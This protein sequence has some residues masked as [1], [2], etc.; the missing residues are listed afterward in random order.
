MRIRNGL[1][2]LVDEWLQ[3][4]PKGKPPHYRYRAAA[5]ELT[6]RTMPIAGTRAFLDAAYAQ[7]HQNWLDAIDA[8]YTNPS[9]ENWRW[10][11]NL[12]MSPKNKSPETKLEKAV[13]DACGDNWSNQ[14]PV[15]SGL[16]GPN[17]D[18]RV[19]IDLAHRK[20]PS[21]FSLIELKVASDN[22]LFAAIEIL[23]Y[24]LVFVWSKSN[25]EKLGYDL[26]TQPVLA[27]ND[28]TLAVL[29]PGSYYDGCDLTELGSALNNA[30]GEFGA[31]YGLALRFEFCELGEDYA[32]DS[33]S[34]CV[35][36]AISGRRRVWV[37]D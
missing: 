30:L 16:V 28:I 15:G 13:I 20:D 35:R 37:S 22:P 25:Q 11:R 32:E 12:N 29:A 9:K 26:K 21:T 6:R 31:Q 27:A 14:I 33:G 34:E 5:N 2:G 18:R 23:M 19:A 17:A 7:I 8:G 24:G 36:S 1:E 10:K 4:E 3:V